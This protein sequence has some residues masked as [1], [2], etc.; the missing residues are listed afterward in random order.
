[1]KDHLYHVQLLRA[2]WPEVMKA[3][4]S[5]IRLLGDLLGDDHDLAVLRHTLAEETEQFGGDVE[6][7]VG[8]IDQRRAELEARARPLGQCIYAEKPQE[9]VRRLRRLWRA[10]TLAQ[11]DAEAL[12]R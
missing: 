4:E 11:R 10:Q 2:A 6:S 1:V 12:A 5:Q 8:A 3:R 9:F 7:L